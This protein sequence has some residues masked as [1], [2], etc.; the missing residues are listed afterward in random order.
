MKLSKLLEGIEFELIKGSMEVE[1]KDISYDS[2]KVSKN[3]LFMAIEG[4]STDGHEYI[5]LAIQNGAVAILVSK[6]VE[7]KNDVTII[8]VENTRRILSKLSMNLFGYPQEKMFYNPSG[9]GFA[10]PTSLYTREALVRS[11]PSGLP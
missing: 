10:S 7:V 4:L 8:K 11:S 9:F 6:D 3:H 1:I 5:D 2:R